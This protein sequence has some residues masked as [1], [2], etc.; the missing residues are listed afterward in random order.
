MNL[1]ASTPEVMEGIGKILFQNISPGIQ[2]HL[3]GPLGAGKTT[4]VRGL[5][6]GFGYPGKVKSP[7]FTLVEPYDFDGFSI[8]HFDL[9]RLESPLELDALGY[10]DYPG[11][12][13]ICLI[14]WP[15]KAGDYLEQPDLLIEIGLMDTERLVHISTQTDYGKKLI[16]DIS[17]QYK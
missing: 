14:E 12:D 9:Y 3:S 7:T 10:R 4:L 17:L 11:V 15:E 16:A 5:L 2:I 8:Y 13:A 1:I 6:R